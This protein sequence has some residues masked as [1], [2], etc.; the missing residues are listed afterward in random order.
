MATNHPPEE[1]TMTSHPN[2]ADR[3]RLLLRGPAEL[4]ALVPYLLGF[5]PASSL[6]A[7]ALA[8]SRL[9][10]IVRLDLLT[11]GDQRADGRPTDDPPGEDTGDTPRFLTAVQQTTQTLRAHGATGA[12][13]I[14][15]GGEEDVRRN[16]EL[17]TTALSGARVP[18][19]D[20]LRV[21][22]GRYWSYQCTNPACCPPAGTPFD[23]TLSVAAAAATA[24]GLV[25]LPDRDA[26]TAR[27]APVTGEA[28]DRMAAATVAAAQY[29]R[30]RIAAAEPSRAASALFAAGRACLDTAQQHYRAGTPI[31]DEQAALMTILL[32]LPELLELAARQCTGEP[33]ELDMWA[34]LTRR[35]DP[36][37]TGA[38]ATVFTLSALL[39]GNGTLA[40][41][42]VQ[43][44]LDVDPDDPFAQRLAAA[45]AAGTDP[46][47]AAALF[48]D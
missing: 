12:I 46:S 7:V 33:W 40:V 4:L 20:A 6:V 41:L 26:V 1:P 44:A 34:D 17:V 13:L 42:A 38:A 24:A 11:A 14:G 3:P 23:P 29:L 16:V 37:F 15:Y 19:L 39:A 10:T 18:V 21:A 35:A 43:R 9:L 2:H 22:D 25:A 8:G 36:H 27:L 32:E 30:D 28:R 48:T 5:H 31:G 45:V 47:T